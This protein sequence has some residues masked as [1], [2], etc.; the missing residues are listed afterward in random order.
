MLC[1]PVYFHL[2]SARIHKRSIV[3]LSKL[4]RFIAARPQLK[5]VRIESHT[6]ERGSSGYN[7]RIS[8]ERAEAIRAY[9][10]G[11]GIPARRLEAAGIGEDRPVD[12][13]HNPE[14]WARNR[15]VELHIL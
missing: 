2:T 9:L 7:R 12:P 8:Q 3:L 13:R 15:R 14:A 4:A 6:D 10:V 1:E 5:K 11:R